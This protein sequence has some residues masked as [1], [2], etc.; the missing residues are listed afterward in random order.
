M[1]CLVSVLML[2]CS[3]M[4]NVMFVYVRRDKLKC[5]KIRCRLFYIC[6]VTKTAVILEYLCVRI[7]VLYFCLV[8]HLLY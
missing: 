2:F 6:S 3:K 7:D 8:V 5:D 4:I 1:L